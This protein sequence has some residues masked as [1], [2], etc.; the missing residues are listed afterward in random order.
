MSHGRNY[1]VRTPGHGRDWDPCPCGAL[2]GVSVRDRVAVDAEPVIRTRRRTV[3]VTDGA[4]ASL[5][6][7]PVSSRER[8]NE[9]LR[10]EFE[11][12]GFTAQSDGKLQR[13]EQSGAVVTIDLQ[14]RKVSID[15][16]RERE[17]IASSGR[18]DGLERLLADEARRAEDQLVAEIVEALEEQLP[19][20]Q[21]EVDA[22]VAEVV[23]AGL[24][25]RARGLGE[26]EAIRGS[27]HDGTLSIKVRV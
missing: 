10:R 5:D 17:V 13:T 7:L 12:R 14:A 24:V 22:A 2:R 6:V 9:L 20:L 8:E 1:R 11:R 25:E 3:V 21:R 18:E 19:G 4:C 16:K 23:G 26:I 15:L 27:A